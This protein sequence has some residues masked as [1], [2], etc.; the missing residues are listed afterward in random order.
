MACDALR[1]SDEKARRKA[2]LA[3]I[4]AY[5]EARLADLLEHVR[6]GFARF[7][8]GDIDMFELDDVI[9]H[10]KRAARELWKFCAVSG[11]HATSRAAVLEEAAATGDLPDWWEIGRPRRRRSG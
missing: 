8:N 11:S 9:H 4:G 7:D 5:H 3:L 2:A 1:M 10:Y 6:D